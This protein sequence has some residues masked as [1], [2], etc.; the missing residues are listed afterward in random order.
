MRIRHLSFLLSAAVLLLICGQPVMAQTG[1]LVVHATPPQA[2][3]Y[4]DG[5]PIV[6]AK[7]HHVCLTAGE[8]KIDLYNYGYKPESRNVTIEA[9]KTTVLM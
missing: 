7:G 4:V 9:H 2:Y 8:H 3:I 5:E 6:D 1:K